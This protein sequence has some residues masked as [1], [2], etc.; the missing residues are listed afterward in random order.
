MEIYGDTHPLQLLPVGL[1]AC[2]AVVVGDDHRAHQQAA[3]L[4]FVSQA[5]DV[6]VVR[7]AQVAPHLVALYVYR[8]Y[9]DDDLCNV[10]HLHKQ[11]EL[12]VWLE[13]GKYAGGV[14]VVE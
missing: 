7:D 12:A 1:G 6:Y 9:D 14:V 3:V 2:L 8:A 4:E 5:E 13:A 10:R 11:A